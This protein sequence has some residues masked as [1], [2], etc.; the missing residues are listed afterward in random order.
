MAN[1]PIYPQYTVDGKVMRDYE[2][3][4][5]YWTVYGGVLM[6]KLD[7]MTPWHVLQT[8]AANNG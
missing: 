3:A 5:L 8:K 2:D 7:Q 1:A 6:Q 4:N